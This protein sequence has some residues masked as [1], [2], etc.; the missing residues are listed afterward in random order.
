MNK[1][2]S[3]LVITL[4]IFVISLLVPAVYGQMPQ[5]GRRPMLQNQPQ[6]A[7][8]R[9]DLTDAQKEQLKQL[10]ET[11]REIQKQFMEK[12]RNL[13]QELRELSQDAETNAAKIEKLRDEMFDLRVEQMK[14]AYAHQKEI[15]KVLTAEQLKIMNALRTRSIQGKAVM[16]RTPHQRGLY[17]TRGFNRGRGGFYGRAHFPWR[18]AFWRIRMWRHRW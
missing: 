9:L 17:M 4:V 7:V 11:Q 13:Q 10:R 6:A 1:F 2:K 5:R 15:R 18:N 8:D 16:S 3:A 12:T 14:N